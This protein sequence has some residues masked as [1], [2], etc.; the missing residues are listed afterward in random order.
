MC[1]AAQRWDDAR[2]VCA[3]IHYFIRNSSAVLHRAHLPQQLYPILI[4]E[5]GIIICINHFHLLLAG[6][7]EAEGRATVCSPIIKYSGPNM[8]YTNIQTYFALAKN[9]IVMSFNQIYYTFAKDRTCTLYGFC[10]RASQKHWKLFDFAWRILNLGIYS[11][12]WSHDERRTPLF[13]RRQT[14]ARVWRENEYSCHITHCVC[15]QTDSSCVRFIHVASCVGTAAL[16]T[17]FDHNRRTLP[18]T[19]IHPL[20]NQLPLVTVP[21]LSEY[22]CLN[23]ANEDR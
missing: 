17:D 4:L 12:W 16:V 11:I 14:L 9:L 23:Y 21:G 22:S 6:L 3:H 19:N 15:L 5:N 13:P 8:K 2:F 20:F 18:L 1:S 7:A 10:F